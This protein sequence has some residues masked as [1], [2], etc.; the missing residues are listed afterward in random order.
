MIYT[1]GVHI[2]SSVSIDDLHDF[3]VFI[4]LSGRYFRDK[5]YPH[6]DIPNPVLR[7]KAL[8]AGAKLVSSMEMMEIIKSKTPKYAE[9]I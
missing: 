8:F 4:G 9:N 5:V 2:V 1:D 3:A 7:R 6:Y